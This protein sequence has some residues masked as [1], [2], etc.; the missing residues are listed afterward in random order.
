MRTRAI[1]RREGKGRSRPPSNRHNWDF[2]MT[3]GGVHR[4]K[5]NRMYKNH[6]RGANANGS[7]RTLSRGTPRFVVTA[8]TMVMTCSEHN[9]RKMTSR[10]HFG[11]RY[12]VRGRTRNN[13]PIHSNSKSRLVVMRRKGRKRKGV[14]RRFQETIYANLPGHETVPFQFRRLGEEYVSF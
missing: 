11:R 8:N 9:P 3:S 7:N 10:G 13:S 14:Y 1:R 5:D 12:R 4:R 2:V 6:R